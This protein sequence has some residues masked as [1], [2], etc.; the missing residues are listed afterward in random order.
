MYKHNTVGTSSD[1]LISSQNTAQSAT[2][3]MCSGIH[4]LNTP[5]VVHEI[6]ENLTSG[7]PAILAWT[8]CTAWIWQR[9]G[10]PLT[11]DAGHAW[12]D[13]VYE[14]QLRETRFDTKCA[15]GAVMFNIKPEGD[16]HDKCWRSCLRILA[17]CMWQ[18]QP[19]QKGSAVFRRAVRLV[20]EILTT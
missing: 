11:C 20:D 17:G 15:Q 19:R 4:I 8:Y 12:T 18:T 16:V 5:S 6:R 2:L 1:H 9:N 14:G 10:Q 13:G 3:Q 7:M